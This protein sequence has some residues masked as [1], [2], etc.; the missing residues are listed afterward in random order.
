L[1]RRENGKGEHKSNEK[2]ASKCCTFHKS[3]SHDTSEC[4]AKK[5]QDLRQTNKNNQEVNVIT[6]LPDNFCYEISAPKRISSPQINDGYDDLFISD[7]NHGHLQSPMEEANV[8]SNQRESTT[9]LTKTSLLPT[10]LAEHPATMEITSSIILALKNYGTREHQAVHCLIDTGCSKGLICVTLVHP[11]EKLNQQTLN[12]K[13]KKGTFT[14]IDSAQKNY[15]ILLSPL[16]VKSLQSLRSCQLACLQ[17]L[18][19]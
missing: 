1:R 5:D 12:W 4:K 17:I 7:Y 9:A 14:T 6:P 11:N 2:N 8:I 13:T 19:R 10:S 16:I 18:I 3:N 15:H